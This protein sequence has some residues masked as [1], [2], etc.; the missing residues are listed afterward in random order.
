MA[1]L[2]SSTA[3]TTDCG[4]P[5]GIVARNDYDAYRANS[6]VAAATCCGR[7][8]SSGRAAA[9]VPVRLL[10]PAPPPPPPPPAVQPPSFPAILSMRRQRYCLASVVLAVAAVFLCMFDLFRNEIIG[11]DMPENFYLEI[12]TANHSLDAAQRNESGRSEL[13][14]VLFLHPGKAGGGSV[15]E[16]YRHWHVRMKSCHPRPCPDRILSFNFTLISVRDPVD[17]FVSAFNWRAQVLCRT[18]GETRPQDGARAT[19]NPDL[20]CKNR[21]LGESTYEESIMIHEKYKSNVSMLAEALCF[22][23]EGREDLKQLGHAR[24]SLSD[25]LPGKTANTSNLVAFVVEPGF[26]FIQQVDAALK[27]IIGL[28]MGETSASSLEE[29]IINQ[30][31]TTS[32]EYEHSSMRQ[33]YHAP[34]LSPLGTCC[35]ARHFAKDYELLLVLRERACRDSGPCSEAIQSILDRRKTAGNGC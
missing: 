9:V 28:V 3:L 19:R 12:S 1:L 23:E 27:W 18:K 30:N 31:M 25:W 33:G 16:R 4:D 20:F 10:S 8:P 24:Y 7:R 29:Y 22:G 5:A 11:L 17:R 32:N 13:K 15:K 21:E 14:G 34:P 26:D 6:G 35:L 2:L